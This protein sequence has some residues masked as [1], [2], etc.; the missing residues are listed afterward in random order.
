MLPKKRRPTLPGEIIRYEFLEPLG[1]THKQLAEALGITRVRI[2]EIILGKRAVTPD[3][4][5]R[6]SRFFNTSVEFWIGLQMDVDIW[7]TLKNRNS[8]Y[9]KIKPVKIAGYV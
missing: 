7:D 3:T 1:I 9:K 2:N 5:L 8:E 6:L 4:A